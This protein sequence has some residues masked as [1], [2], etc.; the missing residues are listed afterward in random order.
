[1]KQ[2]DDPSRRSVGD[3]RIRDDRRS[4]D[5]T[6]ELPGEERIDQ[7]VAV[8]VAQG[9]A[10]DLAVIRG[11]RRVGE[12]AGPASRYCKIGSGVSIELSEGDFPGKISKLASR[13]GK[14]AGGEPRRKYGRSLEGP[15]DRKSTR[16]N[17]SHGY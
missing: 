1:M 6:A 15:P 7:M 3:E 10:E 8:R 12:R 11:R 9:P 4:R 13:R 14:L 17:S 16:L 2:I 5:R